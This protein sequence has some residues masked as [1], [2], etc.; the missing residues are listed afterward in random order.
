MCGI[1]RFVIC[2]SSTCTSASRVL[3][4]TAERNVV[5]IDTLYGVQSEVRAL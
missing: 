2:R 3:V 5:H 4:S 1:V